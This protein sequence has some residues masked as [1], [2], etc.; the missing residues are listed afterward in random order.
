ML[1]GSER[2]ILIIYFLFTSRHLALSKAADVTSVASRFYTIFL[3]LFSPF[4]TETVII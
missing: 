4:M 2:L 1:A 3:D